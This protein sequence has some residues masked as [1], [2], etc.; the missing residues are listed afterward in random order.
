MHQFKTYCSAH[1]ATVLFAVSWLCCPC[2][3]HESVAEASQ[4]LHVWL[5]LPAA[6]SSRL[7]GSHWQTPD[8]GGQID[9]LD[10]CKRRAAYRQ[11]PN[12][13][14]GGTSECVKP[15][16]YGQQTGPCFC[17]PRCQA[18]LTMN[19]NTLRVKRI[20]CGHAGAKKNL[21]TRDAP[22]SAST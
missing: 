4:L 1:D 14:S 17:L 9:I 21:N 2:C 15:V 12:V 5:I 11:R 6:K 22:N 16:G 8:P 18:D 19:R 20:S 7:H 10:R 13:A 3:R